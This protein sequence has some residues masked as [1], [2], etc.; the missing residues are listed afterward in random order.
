MLA[1]AAITTSGGAEKNRLPAKPGG[2]LEATA[3]RGIRLRDPSTI[4]QDGERYWTYFTGRGV[5]SAYSEDLVTWKRGPKVFDKAPKWSAKVVPK[6]DG[7]YWAPDIIKINDRYFLY[8]SV[9]T[10]GK[11]DSAIA[12]ATSPTL[13]PNNPEYKWTDQGVV[14]RSREGEHFNAIDP[15][16]FSDDDGSLWMAFGSYWSGLKLME[17][18]PKTGKRLDQKTLLKAIASA[19]SIEASYLYKKNN[20]Y[21][22][23]LNHG[24]CCR[25]D[26][27]TYHILVGRSRNIAGPYLAKD[28]SRLLDGGGTPVL[29][30]K[31]GPLTGPGHAGIVEKDGQSWFS[32]HFEADDRLKGKATLGIMPMHWSK[33]GWPEVKPPELK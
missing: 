6:N 10:F 25:G 21:Y 28:G 4:V 27:S 32:C 16:I 17:L 1:F 23:F 12:L 3:S 7:V 5:S 19:K 13:N 11:M 14:I 8:Y 9:S 18:D 2:P 31:I 22:L 30:R 33:D 29:D 20:Y 24:S 15:A 26:R